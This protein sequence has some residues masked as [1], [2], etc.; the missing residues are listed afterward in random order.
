MSEYDLN[1]KVRDNALTYMQKGRGLILHR[2]PK[3]YK[4]VI[5][6]KGVKTLDNGTII[7]W[8]HANIVQTAKNLIYKRD[9]FVN[10]HWGLGISIYRPL[11]YLFRSLDNHR[12]GVKGFGGHAR[13][14][15]L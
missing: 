9:H 12:S 8:F 11:S 4:Q 1:I 14:S 5:I 2:Y 7:G 13:M 10:H 6:F 15:N 3:F